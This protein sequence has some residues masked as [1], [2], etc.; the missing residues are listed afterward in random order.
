MKYEAIEREL[1]L[2]GE[3]LYNSLFQLYPHRILAHPA[4]V[5]GSVVKWLSR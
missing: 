1:T 4:R 2:L 3:D 5:A